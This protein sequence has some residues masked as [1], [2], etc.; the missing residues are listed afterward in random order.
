MKIDFN[1]WFEENQTQIRNSFEEHLK[2]IG[3]WSVEWV[4]DWRDEFVK[5]AFVEEFWKSALSSIE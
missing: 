2:E 1:K 3:Y 4:D 5:E